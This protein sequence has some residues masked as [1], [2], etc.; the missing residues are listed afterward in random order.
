MSNAYSKQ[1]PSI[2]KA[3]FLTYHSAEDTQTGWWVAIDNDDDDDGD[4]VIPISISASA[5]FHPIV[6]V[7]RFKCSKDNK[8]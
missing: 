2:A 8:I 5:S 3:F 7:G 6:A 1:R 4:D